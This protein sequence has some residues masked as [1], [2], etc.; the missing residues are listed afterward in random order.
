LSSSLIKTSVFIS[1]ACVAV[2]CG[3]RLVAP[4]LPAM[5]TLKPGQTAS[6]QGVVVT[7]RQVLSDSRCP[8]NALCVWAGE[9]TAE[10][11]VR[12]RG[13]EARY[14]LQLTPLDLGRRLVTHRDVVIEF[15]ALQ[16]HPVA[17][18]PTEQD[19]YRATIE[20]R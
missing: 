19:S 6:V 1:F 11:S 15:Q 9:A 12:G 13:L 3:G 14:E 10:F 5:F 17:G 18:D 16:P 20:V 8:I 7:F 4:T 2:S